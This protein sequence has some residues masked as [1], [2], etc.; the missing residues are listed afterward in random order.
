MQKDD[1]IVTGHTTVKEEDREV[2]LASAAIMLSSVRKDTGC[3]QASLLEDCTEPN[4]FIFY[5]EW[6]S[7]ED[8][9]K[10]LQQRY[11]AVFIEQTEK[12]C[13]DREIRKF[14]RCQL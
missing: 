11:I 5:E 6:V 10:H 8:W 3:L 7:R 13:T 1:F 2:F 4:K 14:T 9:M 12:L